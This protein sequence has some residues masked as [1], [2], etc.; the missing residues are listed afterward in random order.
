MFISLTL[1]RGKPGPIIRGKI[2]SKKKKELEIMQD[3]I[4]PTFLYK[5]YVMYVLFDSRPLTK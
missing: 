2:M 1:I 3:L 4:E 5:P